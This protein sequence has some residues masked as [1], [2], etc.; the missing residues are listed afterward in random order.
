MVLS[1]PAL[2]GSATPQRGPRL[3][4]RARRPA[5]GAQQPSPS[6]SRLGSASP[7]T[8]RATLPSVLLPGVAIGVGV[9]R[10][11]DAKAVEHDDRGAPAHGARLV[12][13]K[14]KRRAGERLVE[15]LALVGVEPALGLLLEHAERVDQRLRH[16]ARV[17]HA[18]GARRERP[19]QRGLRL[20]GQT[21]DQ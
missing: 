6:A 11:A 17:S 19:A 12:C 3:V 7:P 1:L 9:G 18:L 2:V 5:S 14:R 21:E 20:V 8:A 4:D 16:C 13:T 15:Q 10:R